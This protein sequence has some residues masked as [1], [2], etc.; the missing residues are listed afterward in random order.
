M[1]PRQEAPKTYAEVQLLTDSS[2]H[3]TLYFG[4]LKPVIAAISRHIDPGLPRDVIDGN[5][6]L[7]AGTVVFS[8]LDGVSGVVYADHLGSGWVSVEDPPTDRV[9][10]DKAVR[11]Q[12][13]VPP[14]KADKGKVWT[15][16][17]LLQQKKAISAR[18]SYYKLKLN[19]TRSSQLTWL[20]N[21]NNVVSCRAS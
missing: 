4:Q 15:G 6:S 14:P 16:R 9:S 12:F 5:K 1:P 8:G 10:G 7:C 11:Q 17:A 13:V 21:G 19:D 20:V 3:A 18:S 2:E